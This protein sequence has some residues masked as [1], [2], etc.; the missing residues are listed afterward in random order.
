VRRA[1]GGWTAPV[2]VT[3]E[4]VLAESADIVRWADAQAGLGLYPHPDVAA[5][6][7]RFDAELGPH[8]RRWMYHRTLGR[9]DLIRAYGAPGV[10]RWEAAAL[11]A[12]FP[13]VSKI[14]SRYLDIDSGTAAES[15]DRV[16]VVFD[17][18][19]A[20]LADGRPY[21]TGDRFTAADLAFAALSAAVIVPSRYG[22]RLPPPEELPEPFAGEVREMRA[23]PAGR[24]ALRLYDQERP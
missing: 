14:I 24:F 3:P 8:G 2:L 12:F 7:A 11:P 5:L 18:V 9:P 4:R 15:R 10:P 22:I 23:H 21:L 16:R 1:G 13:I 20:R 17:D 19:A 6:E